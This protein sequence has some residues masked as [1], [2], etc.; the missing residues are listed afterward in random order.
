MKNILVTID[1]NGKE[2]V[3]LEKAYELALAFKSKLW[4]MHI[5]APDPDFVGYGVGPDEVRNDR[6]DELRAEHR[7]LQ[8]YSKNMTDRGVDADGLLVDGATIETILKSAEKL[9]AE[10]IITGH[11]E[12]GFFYRAIMGSTAEQL[13]EESKIPLMIVPLKDV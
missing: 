2:K 3:L 7:K 1:F 13:L 6:A 11:E 8:E 5:A 12:H 4:I 9:N 10:L